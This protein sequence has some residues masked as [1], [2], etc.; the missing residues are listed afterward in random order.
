MLQQTRP[1]PHKILHDRYSTVAI[2]F[3][4]LIAAAIVVQL[5]LGWRMADLEGLGRTLLLNLHKSVGISILVL[6]AA[7][8]IWRVMNPPPP[9]G[10]NLHKLEKLAAHYVHLGFY[11]ALFALP[12]TGWAMVSLQRPGALKIFGALPWPAFPGASLIPG[13]RQDAAA[14]LADQAHSALVWVMLALLALHIVGALKHHFVSKDRTLSRMA[15]GVEPGSFTN[16]R[17]LAIPATVALA[18]AVIY[19]PKLPVGA[20]RP[21]PASLAQADIYTDIVGPSLDRRCGFC[22]SDGVSKGGLSLVSYD[23][24]LQ[25][26]RSGAV[27]IPG[28]VDK[29]ELYRRITLPTDHVQYM[30][31]DGKPPLGK[32]EI[33]AIQAWIANGAP[34]T[35]KVGGLK[36]TPEQ[37]AAIK[38]L[39]AGDDGAGAES[40]EGAPATVALPPAPAADKA[41]MAKL[42]DEGFIL[43]KAALNSNLLAADYIATKP[44][45]ADVMADL[46]RLGP[47][48]LSVNLR[49]AGVTDAMVKA[50][51]AYPNLQSLR[52]EANEG[53]TDAAVSALSGAKGLTYLN[54]TGTKVTDAAIAAAGG[55]P[56]L[57]RLYVW[58]T[59]VTPA[60]VD[61]LKAT[62]KDLYVYAGLTAKDVPAETKVLQPVN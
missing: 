42:V 19:L 3:H 39:V 62:R 12:L 5:A 20:A 54:L 13:A 31:K 50:I 27:V 4:W 18:A 33:A 49:H 52:L 53:L 51:A 8:L 32:S 29:S 35:A 28:H 56:K 57:Q 10:T 6:T 1:K 7:R 30:P 25:G 61:R 17:L 60:A 59:A 40:T 36:L 23:P 26:G 24:T 58:N 16:R 47:Q 38:T 2:A 15:P 44:L 37:S 9:H 45:T 41:A 55:L 22:H 21:K 34:R 46:N 43:R 48:L 14:D 11:T